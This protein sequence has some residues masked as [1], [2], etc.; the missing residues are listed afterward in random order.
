[1]RGANLKGLMLQQ[2]A[3]L[4]IEKRTAL[5]KPKQVGEIKIPSLGR[6]LNASVLLNS[7]QLNEIHKMFV[8]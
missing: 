5:E 7:K 8:R 2:S 4:G 1:M 3:N 6:A